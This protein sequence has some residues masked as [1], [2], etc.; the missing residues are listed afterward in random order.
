M[1][2]VTFWI[3]QQMQKVESSAAAAQARVRQARSIA[4]AVRAA[5]VS[6][7]GELRGLSHQMPGLRQLKQVTEQ[8]LSRLLEAQLAEL[9][10]L[11]AADAKARV[12]ALHRH[13]WQFLRGTWGQLFLRADRD[14]RHILHAKEARPTS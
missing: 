4:D 7:P 5:D 1:D 6:V 12:T 14:S 9:A 2:N 13:D 10:S 8:T 3:R 11:S